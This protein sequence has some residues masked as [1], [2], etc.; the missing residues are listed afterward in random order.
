MDNN[1]Q[2][3]KETKIYSKVLVFLISSVLLIVVAFFFFGK[4]SSD[5][6]K[7]EEPKIIIKNNHKIGFITDLHFKGTSESNSRDSLREKE[8]FS[9]IENHM[10]QVFQPEFFVDGGDFIEGTEKENGKSIDIFEKAKEYLVKISAPKYFVIGNHEARGLFKEQ[11][12]KLTGMYSSYYFKDFGDLRMIVIDG[13]EKKENSSEEKEG[14]FYYF[15]ENQLKWLEDVLKKPKNITQ[16]IVFSHYPILE[17]HNLLRGKKI[18]PEDAKRINKIFEDNKVSAVFSGH[19][20]HLL[21]SEKNGI[22]YFVLPGFKKSE[23]KDIHW[24]SCFYEI[25]IGEKIEVKMFYK[26]DPNQEQYET[27]MIPSEEFNRI[28]K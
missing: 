18:L 12:L 15:S 2:N 3:K 7:Q 11:W 28:E 5:F 27:L 9:K 16:T 4:K 13:N 26:K 22:K 25:Y 14:A 1:I 17:E 6:K 23:D 10:N 19:I 20:E 8:F 24:F 21:L